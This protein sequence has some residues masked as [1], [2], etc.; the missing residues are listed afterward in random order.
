MYVLYSLSVNAFP[1]YYSILNWS[2]SLSCSDWHFI[3][4]LGL[5][6]SLKKLTRRKFIKQLIMMHPLNPRKAQLDL[7]LRFTS[8]CW[9]YFTR[10]FL[11]ILGGLSFLN[12]I[13]WNLDANRWE[14][15]SLLWFL[16]WF[17]LWE[18]LLPLQGKYIQ[19]FDYVVC[20]FAREVYGFRNLITVSHNHFLPFDD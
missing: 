12:T 11:K 8:F 20:V 10:Y 1:F 3:R 15:E 7:A 14:L 4:Y 9:L 18:T 5:H 19:Y 17:L 2:L 13:Y 16:V 6:V